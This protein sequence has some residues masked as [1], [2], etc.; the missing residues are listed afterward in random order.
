MVLTEIFY[1]SSAIIFV[2]LERLGNL[3][4]VHSFQR[5]WVLLV[6]LH[7]HCFCSRLLLSFIPSVVPMS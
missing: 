5:N 1:V 3:L 6:F 4:M 7:F 2:L